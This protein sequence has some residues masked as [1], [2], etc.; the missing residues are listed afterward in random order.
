[1]TR[2][3]KAERSLLEVIAADDDSEVVENAKK[4][5]G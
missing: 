3:P 1:M 5:I 4:A 2:S